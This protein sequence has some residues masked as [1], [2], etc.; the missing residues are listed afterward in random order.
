MDGLA[1]STIDQS[2]WI[3]EIGC[4]SRAKDEHS[5]L[6]TTESSTSMFAC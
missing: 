6:L 5:D 2:V 1:E 4:R 3:H